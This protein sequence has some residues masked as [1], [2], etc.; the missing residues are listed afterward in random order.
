MKGV[1]KKWSFHEV[2][3]VLSLYYKK[4]P[5]K[6][7]ARQHNTTPNAI[8]KLLQK[9]KHLEALESLR[10]MK[11]KPVR[12]E[13]LPPSA[14]WVVT[15]P[16]WV[17]FKEVLVWLRQQGVVIEGT[18]NPSLSKLFPFRV[19]TR[20]MSPTQ[21]LF[22][23]NRHRLRQGYAIFWVQGLSR[24]KGDEKKLVLEEVF[25]S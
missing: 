24:E 13:V 9:Y 2:S 25:V 4:V 7:L 21:V 17:E 6:L 20:Y 5:I 15:H 14:R 23:A 11:P 10:R 3:E 22:E 18:K 12:G 8:Q 16:E 19:N 1:R